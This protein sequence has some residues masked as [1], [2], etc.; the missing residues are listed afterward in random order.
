M[1][2]SRPAATLRTSA[3]VLDAYVQGS[4]RS[5]AQ[6]QLDK[7]VPFVIGQR[8]GI[9]M[10]NLEGTHR[11]ID[12]GCAG[13]VHSLGHRHPEVLAALKGALDDGRDTG[14]WAIPNLEYLKLQEK[15]AA[16]APV[17]ELTHAVV[18]LASTT[19]VDVAT[20]FAFRYTGRQRM[21]AYRH[22]YH[23]HSGFA[24]LT[25]GSEVEGIGDYYNLPQRQF[26]SFFERYGDLDEIDRLLTPDNAAIILEAMDYETFEPAS[27]D[28]FE[29][30]S[31]LC[32]ARG[33]LF[34]VDETR[35]GLGRTGRLWASQWYDIEP[36]MLITGKGLSGGLY[37]ASAALLRAE[38]YEKCMNEHD[39][40][41][42]SSLGGNEIS[43]IVANKV[44]DVVSAPDFLAHVGAIS[45][46]L[47]ARL[48][49]VCARHHNLLSPGV[50]HGGTFSVMV[51]DPSAVPSLY[52]ALFEQGVLSHS[53]SVI[54]PAAIKFLP[55][56]I[57]DEAGACEIADAL[58]R[59]ASGTN[60][61]G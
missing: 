47:K 54:E 60:M 20:M 40:S 29:G 39:F 37:P 35:T 53:A 33:I 19:S 52:K 59:A 31:R 48:A 41:Y 32:K 17:P 3:E 61:A 13:G 15:L 51:N 44:L 50:A 7:G 9:Y 34:I 27:S 18:T 56:L 26:V 55:P 2:T 30:I 6:R 4:W 5:N 8:D 43:C 12:C 1:P 25:T 38:I 14:L 11:V 42:I 24:A 23:G 46:F 22:G 36:D 45:Q 28:Y 10:T 16:L 21:L 49:E 57:L 58:D